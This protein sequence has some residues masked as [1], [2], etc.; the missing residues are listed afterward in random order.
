MTTFLKA[1]ALNAIKISVKYSKNISAPDGY[2][3]KNV[4]DKVCKIILGNYFRTYA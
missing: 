4:S 2:K 3:E 1:D